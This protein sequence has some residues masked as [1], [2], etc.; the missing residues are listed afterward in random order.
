MKILLV[1][2]L[3]ALVIYGVVRII[4]L[5]RGISPRREPPRVVAPD[6]DVDFLRDLDW[7]QKRDRKRGG[8]DPEPDNS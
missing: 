3:I 4:E 6:D 5:R 7:Q 2:L 1:I 8:T